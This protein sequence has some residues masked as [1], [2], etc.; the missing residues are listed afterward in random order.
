M[1]RRTPD[2]DSQKAQIERRRMEQD[3]AILKWLRSHGQAVQS[4]EISQATGIGWASTIARLTVLTTLR[5]VR[6]AYVGKD[7]GGK[8]IVTFQAAT[9]EVIAQPRREVP[10][11]PMRP[12]QPTVIPVRAHGRIAL[13]SHNEAPVSFGRGR[14]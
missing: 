5:A 3:V 12:M 2:A 6:R 4:R 7:K 13:S 9:A 11:Q 1:S 8:D 14:E 10:F